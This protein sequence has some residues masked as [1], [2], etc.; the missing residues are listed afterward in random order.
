MRISAVYGTLVL[1]V[2]LSALSSA[3]PRGEAFPEQG[4]PVVYVDD[5]GDGKVG[6]GTKGDPFR[7]L[8]VAI[9]RAPDGAVIQLLPGTYRAEVESFHDPVCAN[10]LDPGEGAEATTGFVIRGKSLT[11]KGSGRELTVLETGAGYGVYI[12]DAPRV[13]ITNLTIT[14]GKRDPDGRA[15]DAAVVVRRS[16]V[17]ID[18]VVIRDNEGDTQ[19]VVV[20]VGGIFGREG[21]FIVAHDNLITRNGWDGITLYRGGF[22]LAYRNRVLR[23]RGVGIATT[24]DSRA[25]VIDNEVSGYW[26]GLGA[27]GSSYIFA[28]R[29]RIHHTLGWGAIAADRGRLDLYNNVIAYHGNVGVAAWHPTST[30]NMV[31]NIVAF[32]GSRYQWVAPRV[33]VWINSKQV[34]LAY[35]DVYGNREG[36]YLGIEDQT[37]KGG[38][39]SVDPRFVSEFDFHLRPDS[40]L[41]DAGD[42]N[43]FDP[44]GSRSDMGAY[45]GWYTPPLPFSTGE[46]ESGV[47]V[48]QAA[49][50]L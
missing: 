21:A 4:P 44:D 3:Y 46:K 30:L 5:L 37:G 35:N 27:F 24:W 48:N 25:V 50:A 34:F 36:E 11:L 26:K 40:P 17:E 2:G 8:E 28:S 31:N 38:N 19:G 6:T 15:A 49:P 18:Q 7:S 12:E 42:P 16:L 23:G 32:N 22:L 10:C 13:R 39:L 29:N 20:G 47:E 1:A 41:I 9:E 33:G 43:I 14:G 45:G